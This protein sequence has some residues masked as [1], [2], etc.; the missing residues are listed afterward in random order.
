MESD[1]EK[2]DHEFLR[3][4]WLIKEDAFTAQDLFPF[5]MTF[6]GRGKNL[7][8]WRYIPYFFNFILDQGYAVRQLALPNIWTV[9]LYTKTTRGKN[10]AQYHYDK[11]WGVR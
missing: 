4:L 6:R 10:A 8:H 1:M 7:P 2:H 5:G 9:D 3:V 11:I